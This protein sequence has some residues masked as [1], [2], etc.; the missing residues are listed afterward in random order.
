MPQSELRDIYPMVNKGCQ[1]FL[2][3]LQVYKRADKSIA[4]PCRSFGG[5]ANAPVY[6]GITAPACDWVVAE[7]CLIRLNTYQHCAR[8]PP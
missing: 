5:C 2:R 1:T 7:A 6:L 4:R 8:Q 3:V